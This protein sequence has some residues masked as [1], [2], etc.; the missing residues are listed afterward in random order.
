MTCWDESELRALQ[1]SIIVEM[2]DKRTFG[3]VRRAYHTTFTEDERAKIT[4]LY[5]RYFYPWYVR[6]GIPQSQVLAPMTVDLI[7]RAVEFFAT[8]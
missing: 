7:R 1:T 5:T 3:R 2:W 4:A 8:I 6:T